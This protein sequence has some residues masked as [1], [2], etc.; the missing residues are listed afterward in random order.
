MKEYENTEIASIP[1]SGR[2]IYQ[3]FIKGLNP[4]VVDWGGM[5]TTNNGFTDTLKT[6]KNN[7]HDSVVFLNARDP[8]L[9][10]NIFVVF[11]PNQIK[12]AIG[13]AGTF[14]PR[15]TGSTTV[16]SPTKPNKTSSGANSRRCARAIPERQAS[17]SA[18]ERW[19]GQG[20]EGVN[21]HKGQALDAVP[22][23]QQPGIQP[24]G[25]ISI[26]TSQPAPDRRLGF[27]HDRRCPFSDPLWFPAAG[28]ERQDQQALLP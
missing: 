28:A 16:R 17:Q 11:D 19:F 3:V 14:S 25:R 20:V 7:G 15:S 10:D 9:I 4:F 5:S 27:L 22:R 21:V 8:D 13:N 1:F 6:A 18:F 26:G 12:S 2:I 24:L 23:H